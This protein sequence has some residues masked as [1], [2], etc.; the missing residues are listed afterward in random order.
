MA[1]Q[2]VFLQRP[3]RSCFDYTVWQFERF[4]AEKE[5]ELEN[6]ERAVC[7]LNKCHIISCLLLLRQTLLW[8]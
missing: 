4:I 6:R 5:K 1:I 3:C 2:K 7:H 8:F